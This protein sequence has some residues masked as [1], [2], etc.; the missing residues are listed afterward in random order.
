[1]VYL[2]TC[3][4]TASLIMTNPL[5]ELPPGILKNVRGYAS[6]RVQPHPTAALIKSLE[7]DRDELGERGTFNDGYPSIFVRGGVTR[8]RK[9]VV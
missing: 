3:C 5:R 7:F 9:S 4:L 8:D 1:M 6:D 2:K